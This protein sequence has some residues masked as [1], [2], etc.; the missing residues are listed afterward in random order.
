MLFVVT[1]VRIF[2]T[3]GS[4]FET[5]DVV[6][7]NTVKTS[8]KRKEGKKNKRKKGGGKEVALLHFFGVIVTWKQ[9]FNTCRRSTLPLDDERIYSFLFF[10]LS[11]LFPRFISL[12]SSVFFCSFLL[13][14][15]FG[16]TGLTRLVLNC[17]PT[18]FSFLYF[19]GLRNPY[20]HF[21]IKWKLIVSSNIFFSCLNYSFRLGI[22]VS[23]ASTFTNRNLYLMCN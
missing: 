5:V 6:T 9:D 1:V 19:F 13:F 20:T 18:Y 4:F 11:F 21:F 8:K 7:D 10:L 23:I 22:L 16:F 14:C 15:F 17:T 3:K 2:F 12:S